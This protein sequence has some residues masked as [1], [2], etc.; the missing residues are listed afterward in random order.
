MLTNAL[1]VDRGCLQNVKTPSVTSVWNER[2]LELS[3]RGLNYSFSL[4]KHKVS[5]EIIRG[6]HG[7]RNLCWCHGITISSYQYIKKI[8]L[9][10]EG[11]T[12]CNNIL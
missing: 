1:A 8:M 9:G 2:G 3:F 4:V 10:Y 11:L 7:S 5:I 12:S 6:V